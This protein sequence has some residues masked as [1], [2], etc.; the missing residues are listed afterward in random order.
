M[1]RFDDIGLGVTAG[2]MQ[3]GTVVMV[4]VGGLVARTRG[5]ACTI[6]WAVVQGPASGKHAALYT[7]PKQMWWLDV[8]MIPG[9]PPI[10]Q[11]YRAD[12]ILGVPALGLSMLGAPPAYPAGDPLRTEPAP[13][14]SPAPDADPPTA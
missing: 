13:Q 7:N 5:H 2:E 8:Y 4:A 10:P 11:M 1:T 6:A 12:Q 9:G 3:T 14:P